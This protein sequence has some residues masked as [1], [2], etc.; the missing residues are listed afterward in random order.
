V[1]PELAQAC[2]ISSDCDLKA[3]KRVVKVCSFFNRMIR[4]G[5]ETDFRLLQG[6]GEEK[7]SLEERAIQVDVAELEMNVEPIEEEEIPEEEKPVSPADALFNLLRKHAIEVLTR[8]NH[9]KK[10]YYALIWEDFT[11]E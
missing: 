8:A 5:K 2:Y 10:G 11:L 9:R 4:D 6:A 1:R 3:L 7:E